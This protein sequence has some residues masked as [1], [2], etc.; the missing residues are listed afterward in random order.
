MPDSAAYRRSPAAPP[1]P[2]GVIRKGRRVRPTGGADSTYGIQMP[3]GAD[4][5]FVHPHR[6]TERLCRG[7]SHKAAKAFRKS[8]KNASAKAIRKMRQ[9][10]ALPVTQTPDQQRRGGKVLPE[11]PSAET[12]ASGS[13]LGA[14][15][16]AIRKIPVQAFLERSSETIRT[17]SVVVSAI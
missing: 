6:G 8:I 3:A 14:A 10:E 11:G 7:S 4:E 5:A 9:T 13:R 17:T 15:V 16:R 12:G 1:H 2:P